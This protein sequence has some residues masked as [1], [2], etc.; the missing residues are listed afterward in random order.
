MPG[1][2]EPVCRVKSEVRSFNRLGPT[3]RVALSEFLKPTL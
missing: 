3:S 1:V 2:L